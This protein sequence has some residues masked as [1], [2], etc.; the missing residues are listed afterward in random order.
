M[1]TEEQ[2][3][4]IYARAGCHVRATAIKAHTRALNLAAAVAL[5]EANKLNFWEELAK[6]AT[7]YRNAA[8][9]VT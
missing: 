3:L 5:E 8:K 9:G 6:E 2:T 7:K 1:I 4:E